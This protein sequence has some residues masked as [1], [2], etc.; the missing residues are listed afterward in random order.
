MIPVETL[1]DFMERANLDK[2]ASVPEGAKIEVPI[3]I[4]I[5]LLRLDEL[6]KL[7]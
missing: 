2:T 1:L 3:D 6:E 5:S 4:V 7:Q